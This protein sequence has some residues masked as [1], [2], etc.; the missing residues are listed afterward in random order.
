M[1]AHIFE[2]R[3]D[4]N[5]ELE[6]TSPKKELEEDEVKVMNSHLDLY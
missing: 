2:T 1:K 6:L 5:D 4:R 3:A